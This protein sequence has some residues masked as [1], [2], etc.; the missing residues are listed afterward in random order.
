MS[1]IKCLVGRGGMHS[2]YKYPLYNMR[3]I[4][5]HTNA[6]IWFHLLFSIIKT[7]L[8]ELIYPSPVYSHSR[9]INICRLHGFKLE[10]G[11]AQIIISYANREGHRSSCK[12]L[13]CLITALHWIFSIITLRLCTMFVQPEVPYR[14]IDIAMPSAGGRFCIKLFGTFTFKFVSATLLVSS[15]KI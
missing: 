9:Q 1:A 8:S 3:L 4:V 15:W 2:P 13:T 7:K 14:K 5:V 11:V 6:D 10:Q 12:A